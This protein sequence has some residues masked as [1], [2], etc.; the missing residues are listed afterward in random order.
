MIDVLVVGGGPAGLSTALYAA[1]AGLQAVVL[2]P[3]PGPVDKACGEGLMPGVVAAL[4]ELGVDPPGHP[5]M[6]IAYLDGQ[7]RCARALF[8]AGPGRGVR[9]TTLQAHLLAAAARTGIPVL[10]R[11]VGQVSQDGGSVTAGGLRARYLLAADGLH[12]PVRSALGLSLPDTR[13]S[14]YGLRR[15]YRTAPWSDLVEVHWAASAEAY[16]TPVAPDL[17]G[18]AIL[19]QERGSF[20]EHLRRF[21]ALAARLPVSAATTTRGAGPLRQ[22]VRARS[23]GRV[24]LVGDASG[25]VDAI[26]GE[27]IAVA[28][29][30][31]RAAVACVSGDCPGR[32]E[33][34]WRRAS[35][36]PRL[37][38]E[39]LLWAR[40]QPLL[41]QR[42]V[43]A[44]TTLPT[45]FARA[46]DGLA[47]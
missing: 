3:R 13:P 21:P 32:Y 29:A 45:A 4:D 9:R 12:S 14:R 6:G 1:R 37:M 5:L 26:T 31:A 10:E 41:G 20:E 23:A 39:S 22:R 46:V 44:A 17:V 36:R 25:Y 27:G 42:I 34:A 15:H 33:A 47:G 19:T 24:L 18:V 2:E 8:R 43:R 28:M 30:S 7:S 40:R 38:T 35:R 11:R 16:V